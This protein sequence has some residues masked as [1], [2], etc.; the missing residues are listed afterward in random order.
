MGSRNLSPQ[1]HAITSSA[2]P[3]KGSR[4][5][6]TLV[7][8]MVALFI[9]AGVM[10]GFLG[11]FL[12]SRRST[13]TNVMHSAATSFVY[14]LMEQIKGASFTDQLPSTVN[15]V[16]TSTTPSTTR[17]APFIRLHMDQDKLVWLRVRHQSDA[18]APYAP[19]IT[20]APT[21]AASA[22]GSHADGAIDNIIS[23]PLSSSASGAASQHLNLNLWAWVDNLSDS[24]R[25]ALEV[26]RVTIVYSY[27]VN[28]GSQTKTFR[29]REVLIR[30]RYDK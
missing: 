19:T 28:L 14:G 1:P 17:V 27:S 24:T 9:L 6:V 2:T 10:L 23:I 22:A 8:S 26:K 13:E 15:E 5:G 30:T 25:D 29:K 3:R 7:E 21:V 18:S 4:S 20:P 11:T 12:Q 16:D